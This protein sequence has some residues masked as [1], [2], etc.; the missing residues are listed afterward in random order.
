MWHSSRGEIMTTT[1]GQETEP[2]GSADRR[3]RL[4]RV[5]AIVL[6]R[7]DLGETDRIV[8]LLTA[9]HGKRR[10]VAKGS[11]R[12]S[13]RIAGHL[14]PFCATRLLIA[15]TRGMDIISQAETIDPFAGLRMAESTI[16][17]AGYLAELVDSLVQEDEAHRELYD[18][19]FASY[20]LL[21]EGRDL[22]TVTFLYQMALLRQ[23]GYRPELAHCI[24]C[25][26][27]VDP[28]TNGFSPDGGVL[29]DR[30]CRL[31]ADAAPVGVNSLKL[32]R[33]ADRGDVDLIYGLRVPSAVWVEIETAL[34]QY[35][36]RIVGR[37]SSARRVIGE[38]RLE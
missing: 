32:L 23:L 7:R 18:L 22:R 19:L 29:C 28:V 26:E 34:A 11:R 16:A 6:R 14:E 20:R 13:S 4:Y 35:I 38:L 21:A 9:E 37:D 31:R 1:P 24:V 15:R 12:P 30:C 2:D 33:A 8:T 3:T 36:A 5:H 27:A 25:R 17:V 10:V